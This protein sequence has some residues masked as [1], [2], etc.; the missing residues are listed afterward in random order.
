MGQKAPPEREFKTDRAHPASPSLGKAIN[1]ES[2]TKRRV[3]AA[4]TTSPADVTRPKRRTPAAQLGLLGSPHPKTCVGVAQ[5]E[6]HRT[7]RA[8]ITFSGHRWLSRELPLWVRTGAYSEVTPRDGHR[9]QAEIDSKP[10]HWE[11]PSA[12]PRH[13]GSGLTCP[14]EVHAPGSLSGAGI[15]V[16]GCSAV[17]AC[18]EQFAADRGFS[19]RTKIKFYNFHKS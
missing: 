9:C 19:G 8:G 12:W 11:K 17:T 2:Q 15:S 10:R 3:R 1:N 5:P 7:C 18:S 13:S 14:W 6:E 4:G 16:W